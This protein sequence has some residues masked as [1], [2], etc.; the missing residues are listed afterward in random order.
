MNGLE[1]KSASAAALPNGLSNAD[2][3]TALEGLKT[4]SKNIFGDLD[5]RHN[6]LVD[7][8][9]GYFTKHG[10]EKSVLETRINAMQTQLDAVDVKTQGRTYGSPA[11]LSSDA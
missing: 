9:K 1:L 11:G 2:I 6:N 8:L 10:E 4:T 3:M 5:G 7:Q